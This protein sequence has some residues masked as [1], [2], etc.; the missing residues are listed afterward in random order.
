M[1]LWVWH[2][3]MNLMSGRGPPSH[4]IVVFHPYTWEHFIQYNNNK[5][6]KTLFSTN[7]VVLKYWKSYSCIISWYVLLWNL[8]ILPPLIKI[9]TSY[10]KNDVGKIHFSFEYLHTY[11]YLP[12]IDH[13]R[14]IPPNTLEATRSV[15]GGA[16]PACWGEV[17]EDQIIGGNLCTEVSVVVLDTLSI[18]EQVQSYF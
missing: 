1:G 13:F 18:V 15:P 17:E 4:S 7:N 14:L 6:K 12:Q 11:N 2:P 3:L 10:L 5:R 8:Q 16:A 9:A